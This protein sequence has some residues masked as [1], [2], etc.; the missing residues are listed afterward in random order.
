MAN[1][2]EK[3]LEAIKQ[4]EDKIDNYFT[5]EVRGELAR[6][7]KALVLGNSEDI[8][9]EI[10]DTIHGCDT[11]TARLMDLGMWAHQLDDACQAIDESLEFDE[12]TA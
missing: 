12:E 11:A 6:L 8:A 10:G 2:T 9:M 5:T 1:N 4:L 7:R 3:A